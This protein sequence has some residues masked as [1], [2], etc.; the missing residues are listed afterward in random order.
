MTTT[1]E[2]IEVTA[3]GVAA[4]LKRR[5]IGS[6]EKVTLTIEPEQEISLAGVHHGRA[7]WR[8]GSPMTISTGSSSR[9][10][11]TLSR[12]LMRVV[13]DTNVFVQRPLKDK[14]FPALALHVVA[15][16]GTLLKSLSTE[17]QLFAVLARPQLVA[18][19][20]PAAVGWMRELMA[21]PKR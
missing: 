12:S 13:V 6:D 1:R 2:T 14:S 9:R 19:V 18:L 4:E 16:R 11:G 3:G 7:S 5:G 15:Q 10:K 20:D 21:R 17:G 8:Q